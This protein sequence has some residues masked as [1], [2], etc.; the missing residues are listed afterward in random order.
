MNLLIEANPDLQAVIDHMADSP[1]EH[2]EQ[3]EMLLALAKYPKVFAKISHMW[4]LSK[5]A[6]PYPDAAAQVKRLYG[7]FG[8]NRLMAGTDWPISLPKQSYAQTVEL[9][10]NHLDFLTPQDHAQIV[11]KTVQE[12][13]PLNID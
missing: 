1:L 8:A 13:W 10:R 2:P 3:L 7:V 6:Y 12:V 5:E 11:S 9:Y 4:S